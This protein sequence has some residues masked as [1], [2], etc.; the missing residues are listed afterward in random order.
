MGSTRYLVGKL[1]CILYVFCRKTSRAYPHGSTVSTTVV[2]CRFRTCKPGPKA[3]PVLAHKFRVLAAKL[4]H[5]TDC[6]RKEVCFPALFH[7]PLPA[8]NCNGNRNSHKAV[9]RRSVVKSKDFKILKLVVVEFKS[10]AGNVANNCTNHSHLLP[11][12]LWKSVC[13]I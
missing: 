1:F 9:V 2:G 12:E 5:G 13:R 6:F 11:Y 10:T 3:V 8:Q 4:P 7:L